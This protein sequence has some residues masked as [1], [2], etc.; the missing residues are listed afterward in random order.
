[1]GFSDNTGR[2]KIRSHASLVVMAEVSWSH[3]SF[4][5]LKTGLYVY[6]RGSY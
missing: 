4:Q 3:D 2:K 1:M 5:D 6:Y